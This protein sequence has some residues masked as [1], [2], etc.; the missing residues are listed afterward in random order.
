MMFLSLPS[1]IYALFT[2]GMMHLPTFS[3]FFFFS[4]FLHFYKL[5]LDILFGDRDFED[6]SPIP[7]STISKDFGLS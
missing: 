4:F 2:K 7:R 6:I 1:P 3:V 5:Q